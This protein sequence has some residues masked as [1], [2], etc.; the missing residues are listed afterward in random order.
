[1]VGAHCSVEAPKLTWAVVG[2]S[3]KQIRASLRHIHLPFPSQQTDH[4]LGHH[5]S[6]LSAASQPA[7][8]TNDPYL[9][10]WFGVK[11]QHLHLQDSG[12][13]VW[14]EENEKGRTCC[15]VLGLYLQSI[16]IPSNPEQRNIYDF[17]GTSIPYFSLIL[18]LLRSS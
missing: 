2:F 17:A 8:P 1:M 5:S 12:S 3:S 9:D 18:S 6:T 16:L 13:A 14:N 7:P 15:S 10:M 11:K 4:S